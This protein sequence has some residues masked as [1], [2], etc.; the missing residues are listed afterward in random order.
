M[1]STHRPPRPSP[2]PRPR[3]AW[4]IAG[5][6]LALAVA[7]ACLVLVWPQALGLHRTLPVTQLVS[8]RLVGALGLA[9][10]LLLVAL[11]LLVSRRLRA[12]LAASATVLLVATLAAGGVIL[13]RGTAASLPPS[14]APDAVRVLARN[15]LGNE[16]GSPT[17]ARLAL[18]Y[19]VDVLM[20]PETTH[21]MGLEIASLLREAGRPMWVLSSN[22]APGYRAAETTLLVSA[23]LGEYEISDAYGDTAVLASVV[24]EPVDGQGPLLVAA[25]PVAP[26]PEQMQNWRDD[27]AWLAGVCAG[28]A[29][30][31]GDFNATLDHLAGLEAPDVAGAVLGECR[32]AAREAGSASLGTWTSGKPP[33]LVPAIDHVMHTPG[34]EVTGFEVITREDRAG[35]DHRPV[36]A[37]LTRAG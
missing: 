34:W 19:D 26:V 18:D 30:V 8:F 5:A 33:L 2:R 23:E 28:D 12:L 4:G 14:G 15:T 13:V 25:H 35:S 24:A 31:A 20:L 11:L 32:D 6:I 37:E 7:A 21:D 1:T 9:G 17:I 36:F 16:P 29:I 27:L 22:P 3:P 10:A